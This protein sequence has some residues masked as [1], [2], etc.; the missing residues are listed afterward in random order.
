MERF[1]DVLV[2]ASREW[3]SGIVI[4]G[5]AA[6]RN[7]AM[8]LENRL[9]ER[10]VSSSLCNLAGETTLKQL[11]AVLQRVDAVLSN[12]SGPMHLAAGLGTPTLGIFT[13]TDPVRSGPAGCGHGVVSTSLPCGGSY[14]KRC[15][16]R[17]EGRLACFREL[18]A[19]RVWAAF[20]RLMRERRSSRR[21]VAA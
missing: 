15:P 3:N 5:S 21:P 19:A 14:R 13:C 12:D 18:D 10:G 11:A 9:A 7:E 6:E 16:H 2:R 20:E 17:G 1:A 4:L 8:V